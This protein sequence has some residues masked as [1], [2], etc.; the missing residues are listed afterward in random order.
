MCPYC[1]SL[2]WTAERLGSTGTVY[3]YVIH[4]Q[5]PY[6][7]Y[8]SPHTIALVEMAP[9]IRVLGALVG[10]SIEDVSIGMEVRVEFV[11]HGEGFSLH[12]FRPAGAE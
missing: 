5:P 6:P 4:H 2:K 1:R 10:C 12:R 8:P 9:D 11:E 3:S 7:D